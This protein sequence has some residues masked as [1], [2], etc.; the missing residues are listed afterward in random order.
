VKW[1]NTE[2][3]KEEFGGGSGTSRST[4]HVWIGRL[5]FRWRRHGKCVYVD[6]HNRPDVEEA[7][8]EYVKMMF[9]LRRSMAM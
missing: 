1:V 8:K 3:L 5:G 2:L 6:G 7:R 4:A 9:I